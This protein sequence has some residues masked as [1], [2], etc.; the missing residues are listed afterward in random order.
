MHPTQGPHPTR[1]SLKLRAPCPT[2][3]PLSMPPQMEII[4]PTHPQARRNHPCSPPMRTPPS[5]AHH[6]HPHSLPPLPHPLT[7]PLP[8]LLRILPHLL[9]PTTANIA[10]AE[11]LL[12]PQLRIPNSSPVPMDKRGLNLRARQTPGFASATTAL[13]SIRNRITL[14]SLKVTGEDGLRPLP[15]QQALWD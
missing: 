7:P 3:L 10:Q 11:A 13:S 2:Y 4:T 8:L 12:R 1:H 5:Q 9:L 15:L 6:R 14:I